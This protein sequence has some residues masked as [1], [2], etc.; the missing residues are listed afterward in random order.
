MHG[1]LSLH[2]GVLYVGRHA[3]TAWVAT[4]DLDGRALDAG[5]SFRDEMTGRSA[6]SGL[7]VDADHRVWIADS[8]ARRVRAFTLF[9]RPVA[10]VGDPAESAERDAAGVLGVPVDVRTFGSD[11][12]LTVVVAS[13]G[14]RRHALQ[15]FHPHTGRVRSLRPQGDPRGRFAGLAGIDGAGD[16]DWLMACEARAGRVSVFRGGEFHYAL[17][18]P[19]AGARFEPTAV[20]RLRDGRVVI[21][22]GGEAGALLLVDSGGRLLRV[23]AG[24]G[25][26]TGALDGPTDV[27]AAEWGDDRHTRVVSIDREGERVQVFNLE[28]RCYGAFSRLTGAAQPHLA[29]GRA[30]ASNRKR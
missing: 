29:P 3:K 25:E 8:A 1:S 13:G 17:R 20:A 6:A 28:G 19:V 12:A 22:N 21:A 14:R 7:D 9:G 15:V 30:R 16:G 2:D 23:L 11:D 24:A 4:Y 10:D 18:V 26:G 27:V 5:F